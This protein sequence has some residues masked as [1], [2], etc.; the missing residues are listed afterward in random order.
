MTIKRLPLHVKLFNENDE[1]VLE[2]NLRL[3]SRVMSSV[4][5]AV[6]QNW[7]Y[8]TCRVYYHKSKGYWNEFRF[9]STKQ[10]KRRYLIDTEPDLLR[11]FLEDGTLNPDY[12]NKP[13]RSPK[14]MAALAK[15]RQKSFINM[16][17]EVVTA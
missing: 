10:L 13:T 17:D 7:K 1:V 15:A 3:I 8:G 9:T 14:Q 12:L 16:K 11:V 2:L 6:A 5:G 4:D